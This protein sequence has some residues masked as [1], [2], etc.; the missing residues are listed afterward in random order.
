L[1]DV[2]GPWRVERA[3]GLKP[4]AEGDLRVPAKPA[5]AGWGVWF[6]GGVL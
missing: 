6:F 5:C 1:P 4:W 3:Q 2:G